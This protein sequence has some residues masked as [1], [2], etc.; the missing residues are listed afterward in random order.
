VA[1]STLAV[2][3]VHAQRRIRAAVTVMSGS[4]PSPLCLLATRLVPKPRPTRD[5]GS[6]CVLFPKKMVVSATE[7]FTVP[8]SQHRDHLHSAVRPIAF[9]LVWRYAVRRGNA[10]T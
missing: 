3:K 10:S 2:L 1:R 4:R 5:S 8:R 6:S 9:T 7:D